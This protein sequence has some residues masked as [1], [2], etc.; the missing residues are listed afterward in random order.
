[1]RGAVN[2]PGTTTGGTYL[3]HMPA[4]EARHLAGEHPTWP[5]TPEA[6]I[7]AAL[8]EWV[9]GLSRRRTAIIPVRK[10]ITDLTLILEAATLPR[11]PV[12]G[13]FGPARDSLPLPGHV[14]YLGGGIVRLDDTALSSLAGLG[15]GEDFRVSYTDAGPVLKVGPDHYLARAEG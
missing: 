4:A 11:R 13:P 3:V 1:M 14:E 7:A 2:D 8:R 12:R 6:R 10:V 5:A 9:H 15:A